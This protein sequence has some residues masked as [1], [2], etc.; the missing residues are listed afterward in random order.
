M[1]RR[2][3]IYLLFFW[4]LQCA[5]HA[6]KVAVVDKQGNPISFV[7]VRD[8]AGNTLGYTDVDGLLPQIPTEVKTIYLSHMAFEPLKVRL[9]SIR[10]N[11]IELKPSS[12]LLNEVNVVS[13]KPFIRIRA[14]FRIYSYINSEMMLYHSGVTDFYINPSRDQETWRRLTELCYMEEPYR[15]MYDLNRFTTL[16]TFSVIEALN[17]DKRYETRQDSASIQGIYMGTQHVGNIVSDSLNGVY[18]LSMDV[19]KIEEQKNNDSKK[20]RTLYDKDLWN[21]VYRMDESDYVSMTDFVMR[22]RTDYTIKELKQ[23][24]MVDSVEVETW[25]PVQYNVVQDLYAIEI[26]RLTRSEVRKKRRQE[27]LP[28]MSFNELEQYRIEHHIPDVDEKFKELIVAFVREK[29]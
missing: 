15:E 7:T 21:I 18:R 4:A 20:S 11:R 17:R 25:V 1:V 29:E 6:Q 24:S 27:K 28:E 5:V 14:F 26:E 10:R 2:L 3:L 19:A 9:A 8:D 22:N 12:I 23:K 13:D 16:G